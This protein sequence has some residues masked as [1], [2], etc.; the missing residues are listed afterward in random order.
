MEG[1]R[2]GLVGV[3]G[4]LGARLTC[5]AG[6]LTW[7]RGGARCGAAGAGARCGAAGAGARCG[8]GGAGALMWLLCT[9]LIGLTKL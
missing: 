6:I 5:A 1:F 4:G 3:G 9:P 7:G 8:L 2:W